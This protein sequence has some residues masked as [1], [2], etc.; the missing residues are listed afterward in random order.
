M[1]RYVHVTSYKSLCYAINLTFAEF[2]STKNLKQRLHL[3]ELS[4]HAED[5][6][7][8]PNIHMAA[9]NCL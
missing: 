3:R 4:G 5:L 9:H 6:F 1:V 8:V 2:T 7:L